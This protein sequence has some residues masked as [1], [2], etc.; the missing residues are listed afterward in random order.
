ML[1][2]ADVHHGRDQQGLSARA[3]V[4]APTGSPP[5]ASR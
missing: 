5:R 1:M 3:A 2:P 4:L